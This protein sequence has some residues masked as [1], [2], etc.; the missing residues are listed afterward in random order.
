[1]AASFSGMKL[2]MRTQGRTALKKAA[3]LKRFNKPADRREFPKAV[4]I[5]CRSVGRTV[6]I[7][8]WR[9]P[10]LAQQIA[11]T[12]SREAPHFQ[13]HVSGRLLVRMDDGT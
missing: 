13:Y 12:R 1:M 5:G 9:W 8:G 11:K 4:S 2:R 7:P 3:E 10:T 6:F